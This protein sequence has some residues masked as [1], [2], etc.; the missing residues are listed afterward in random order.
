MIFKDAEQVVAENKIT[1]LNK[2]RVDLLSGE[3][4]NVE[5]G[6]RFHLM[7]FSKVQTDIYDSGSLLK[8]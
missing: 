7:P 4:T 6:E 5:S 3:L 8:I 2:I 1:N